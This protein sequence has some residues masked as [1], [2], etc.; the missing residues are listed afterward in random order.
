MSVF[1]AERPPTVEPDLAASLA[2][3]AGLA[4]APAPL[5]AAGEER[6]AF[7]AV[8]PA[9]HTAFAPLVP[10][11]GG[12][13]LARLIAGP[14]FDGE[15]E[16][17]TLPKEARRALKSGEILASAES[18]VWI[19]EPQPDGTARVSHAHPESFAVLGESMALWLAAEARVVEAARA[20]K[21]KKGTAKPVVGKPA[22][23]AALVRLAGSSDVS[24]TLAATPMGRNENRWQYLIKAV[25]ACG[26]VWSP[27]LLLRLEGRLLGRL[28]AG[29]LHDNDDEACI[30]DEGDE[31][32]PGVNPVYLR[33]YPKPAREH[34]EAG[35]IVA[36]AGTEHWVIRREA[37]GAP[38]SWGISIY[39]TSYDGFE[40]LGDSVE[41][42]LAFELDRLGLG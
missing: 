29:A 33:R 8:L 7:F 25:G 34:L 26:P 19:L 36:S 10:A 17:R 21:V 24:A 6:A 13:L 39:H 16:A 27:A 31:V 2:R 37:K 9:L 32:E 28:L 5:V 14:R 30:L 3:L 23:D 1:R 40:H 41:A 38:S 42:W 18:D 11:L 22:I 20:P 35:H 15:P 12:S 4:G